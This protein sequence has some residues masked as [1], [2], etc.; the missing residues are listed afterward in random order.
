MAE[1]QSLVR[2]APVVDAITVDGPVAR[3]THLGGGRYDIDDILKKL[4]PPPDQPPGEPAQFALYNL[5]LN[6]GSF[7]FIDNAVGKTHTVRDLRLAVPFPEQPGLQARGHTDPLLAFKLNGS[8]FDSS[9]RSTPFA[10][11]RKTDASLTLQA[12]DL[13][14]YLG[15]LPASAARAP[16]VGRAG[17]ADVKLAF[18]QTPAP[19][20]RL[21]GTV[22]LSRVKLADAKDQDLLAFERLKLGLADVRPLARAVKLS[23]IELNQPLLTVHRA[24][25]G[26]L[27]LDLSAPSPEEG[28]KSSKKIAETDRPT[29][30]S[31]ERDAKSGGAGCLEARCGL[32][33]GARRPGGLDRRHHCRGQGP[34]TARLGVRDLSLDATGIALPFGA[35]GAQAIPVQGQRR[36][37]AGARGRERR[38][39]PRARPRPRRRRSASA[40]RRSTPPPA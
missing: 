1:L 5:A 3:L 17:H 7:D 35:P 19:A 32:G 4:A 40:A 37:G 38:H 11:T 27:N 9:A 22:Q 28:K 30:G 6:G 20:V 36:A 10:Q 15:Y 34:V 23:A 18:E 26:R 8:A 12:M 16:A 31:K 24:R 33:G 2:M 29:P 25:D 21:S 14:P 13:S 39:R